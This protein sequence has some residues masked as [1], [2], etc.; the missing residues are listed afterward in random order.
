LGLFVVLCLLALLLPAA[1]GLAAEKAAFLENESL[2][3]IREKIVRNGYSFTVGHTWVYDLSPSERERLKGRRMPAALVAGEAEDNPGPLAALP[4]G[5]ALP[6]AFDWRDVNGRSYI[7]PIRN[8]GGCGSC[9]AFGAAAAA[10]GTYNVAMGRSGSACADFSE[11]FIAW[12]LGEYGPYFD[13]FNG[14]EGADYDYAELTALTVEGIGREAAFPYTVSDP[15]SCSHWDDPRV[16]FASWHR[17]PCN[18]IVAMKTALMTYG[19]LDVAVYSNTSAF[20]G[21]TG[22][23]Y[24]D[25]STA[26]AGSP[27]CAYVQTD[28][29][30]SLVGWNDNGDADT[31]GYWILRNSWGTTWGEGGYMRIKYTSARVACA[32]CYLVYAGRPAYV[33]PLLLQLLAE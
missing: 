15:G 12:C 21:Y 25:T 19:V 31:E 11:S 13:H 4:R 17:I 22:G 27:T 26:C 32:A 3:A 7:G 10:E 29:A 14:C 30:V 5:A 8:Q 24:E 23:V 1:S 28:H 20:D 16:R 2:E 18:D 9:Y 33:T 6:A